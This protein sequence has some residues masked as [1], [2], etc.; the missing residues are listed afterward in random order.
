[1]VRIRDKLMEV[2]EKKK[3]KQRL[4]WKKVKNITKMMTNPGNI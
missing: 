3:T 4:G 1:M 2:F